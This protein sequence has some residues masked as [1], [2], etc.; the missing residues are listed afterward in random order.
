[1]IYRVIDLFNLISAADGIYTLSDEYCNKHYLAGMLL[2]EV[3]THC[4]LVCMCICVC[5][6]VFVYVCMCICVCLYV[7]MCICSVCAY[8]YMCI[9]VCLYVC[10]CVCVFV[11]V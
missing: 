11:Y 10:M 4:I 5:A 2:K 6:C 9:C 1:M 7:C 3:Y 8:V